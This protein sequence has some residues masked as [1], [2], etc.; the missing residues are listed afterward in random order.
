MRVVWK[1][2]ELWKGGYWNRNFSYQRNDEVVSKASCWAC[3]GNNAARDRNRF[4][5]PLQNM[6]KEHL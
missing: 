2:G 6:I 3:G 4:A 1:L 5:L